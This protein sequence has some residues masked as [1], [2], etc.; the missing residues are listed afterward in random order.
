MWICQDFGGP[1]GRI[2]YLV[3]RV[4]SWVICGGRTSRAIQYLLVALL[5]YF[6]LKICL[7]AL[8]TS[9]GLNTIV[10]RRANRANCAEIYWILRFC[11]M[12]IDR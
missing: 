12:I 6:I 9:D 2:S 5:I 10:K 8:L 4:Y 1:F 11:L 7:T 3:G